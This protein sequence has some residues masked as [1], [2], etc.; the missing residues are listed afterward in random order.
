MSQHFNDGGTAFVTSNS[1]LILFG[2]DDIDDREILE[3]IFS[4]IDSS[5]RLHFMDN[6]LKIVRYFDETPDAEIPCLV[7]LDYNMPALNGADVLRVLADHKHFKDVP[8]II[9][10]TSG[11]DT[12]KNLCLELGAQE[13][14]V[15][16]SKIEPLVELLK[17]FVS[18][19]EKR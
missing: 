18:F 4:S 16:P 15:K 9:W 13:Y 11:S 8:K 3:D 17:H 19:C 10:S 14:L 6:G 1:K 5:V 2:E 12:Y 7:V